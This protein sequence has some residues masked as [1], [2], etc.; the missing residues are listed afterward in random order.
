[1]VS[2]AGARGDSTELAEVFAPNA[3]HAPH[4]LPVHFKGQGA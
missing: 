1:M 3:G 2:I 4:A